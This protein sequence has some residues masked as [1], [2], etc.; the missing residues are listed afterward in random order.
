M[1]YSG[2]APRRALIVLPARRLTGQPRSFMEAE[3]ELR[4]LRVARLVIYVARCARRPPKLNPCTRSTANK[5]P[6]PAI[7]RGGRCKPKHVVR[8]W[9]HDRRRWGNR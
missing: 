6:P 3:V 4:S 5:L 9:A 1:A 7:G 8:R 2:K